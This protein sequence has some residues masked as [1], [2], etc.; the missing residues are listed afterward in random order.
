MAWSYDIPSHK[1]YVVIGNTSSK[2][3]TLWLH[4]H[5][6][7]EVENRSA[8]SL[9]FFVLTTVC[10]VFTRYFV[11]GGP[12]K[13]LVGAGGTGPTPWVCLR[14]R[15]KYGVRVGALT[16]GSR[17]QR[18]CC[19]AQPSRLGSKRVDHSLDCLAYCLHLP[20]EVLYVVEQ[21][22]RCTE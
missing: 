4:E 7:R 3:I 9:A 2:G 13:G 8:V 21:H 20:R 5:S 22:L 1:G 17:R 19:V 12:D 6:N 10:N 18:H 11:G 15:V 14:R 16:H